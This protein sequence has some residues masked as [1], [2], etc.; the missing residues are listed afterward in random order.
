MGSRFDPQ[1]AP[2]RFALGFLLISGT[3]GTG[4]INKD[5]DPLP[6][7]LMSFP[8]AIEL[9]VDE[10]AEGKPKYVY[11]TSSNFALQYNSGNVQS[12]DLAKMIA[13]INTGCISGWRKPE[14]VVDG[15]PGDVNAPDCLC[16][17]DTNARCEPVPQGILQS[18]LDPSFEGDTSDPACV[19]DPLAPANQG[20]TVDECVLVPFDRCTVVPFGLQSG[21]PGD[22]LRLIPVEGLLRGEVEIGSF[23]DG[24]GLSTDGRRIYVPVRSDGNLTFIDVNEEGELSCGAPFGERQTCSEAYRTG[25]AELV[26]P[27]EDIVLPPDP[28]DV[29]VGDLAADFGSTS[30]PDD[31]AFR[32]DYIL[33]AHREGEASLFFDQFRADGPEPKKR[34]RLAA[35]VDGLAPEQVTITYEAGSKRAWIPSAEAAAI[36]RLG[37][38]IDG[39]PTQSYLFNSGTLFVA[40]LDNGASNRDI[41]FDPRPDRDLAYIVSRSPEA[42]VVART[43]VAGQNLVM[44]GQISTCRDPSRL[45]V[46]E[47]PARGGTALLAFVSCFLPRSVQVLDTDF[48]QGITLLTNISGAFEFVIDR[49]RLLMYIADFSTSVIR[50]ADLRPLVACLEA[51]SEMPV[52]ECSP[53]LIG[54][55]GLP[56]PVSELPR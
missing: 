27:S 24:L 15:Y 56:Q 50:V 16:D 26:N 5:G 25:S 49:P 38:G 4:C 53:Q 51:T 13:A 7:G 52:D 33:M 44:L 47:I 3:I 35:T 9:S 31:P 43:N 28:V 42:L 17:P 22:A 45:Q 48:F 46:A 30:D 10:D 34:P 40:G 36:V 19:C 41:Q 2:I 18:C 37:I 1:G 11:V 6:P 8:I 54:L 23:S 29:Y 32:G 20:P 39:D 14:C 12:Y 55:V 21:D